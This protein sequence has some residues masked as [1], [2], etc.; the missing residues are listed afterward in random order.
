MWKIGRE[1]ASANAMMPRTIDRC[2]VKT[3]CS[4]MV[5]DHPQQ[6]SKQHPP[7]P[8]PLLQ[9]LKKHP[10]GSPGE[11]PQAAPAFGNYTQPTL[12]NPEQ[13]LCVLEFT[14][15]RYLAK[16]STHIFARKTKVALKKQ[17]D[18]QKGGG[19]GPFPAA[20]ASS[21]FDLRGTCSELP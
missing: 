7:L 8:M 14:F 4:E 19:R 9:S 15:L 13:P 2:W 17:G 10:G 1:S 18:G 21:F 20:A 11:P 16:L 5:R 6:P 12:S 3:E